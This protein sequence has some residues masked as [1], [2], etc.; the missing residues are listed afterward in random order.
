MVMSVDREASLFH[1]DGERQRGVR[2]GNAAQAGA[3]PAW[4]YFR[5]ASRTIALFGG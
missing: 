5:V 3:K 1:D 4:P 2:A